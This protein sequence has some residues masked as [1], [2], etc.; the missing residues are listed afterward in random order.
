M[1]KPRVVDVDIR[2]P[3]RMAA[4]GIGFADSDRFWERCC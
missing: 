3:V 1:E 2:R 4:L